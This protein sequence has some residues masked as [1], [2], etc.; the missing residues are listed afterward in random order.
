MREAPKAPASAFAVAGAVWS[1]L[2]PNGGYH[3]LSSVGS[4]SDEEKRQTKGLEVPKRMQL[5]A[6]SNAAGAFQRLLL[7]VCCISSHAAI[8]QQRRVRYVQVLK[9]Y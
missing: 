4:S 9:G 6:V 5:D 2:R 1:T 7:V 8:D 3:S